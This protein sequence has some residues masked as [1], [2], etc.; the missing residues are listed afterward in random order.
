MSEM[1]SAMVKVQLSSLVWPQEIK[2]VTK[3]TSYEEY[4]KLDRSTG[5]YITF[6]QSEIVWYSVE[7]EEK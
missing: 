7:P 3:V 5:G 6:K 4:L 1:K 2:G